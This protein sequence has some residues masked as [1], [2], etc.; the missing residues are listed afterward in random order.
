MVCSAKGLLPGQGGKT[1]RFSKAPYT[2][3]PD[4]LSGKPL[5]KCCGW[6]P[7]DMQPIGG[8]FGYATDDIY[9]LEACIFSQI[10]RNSDE[11][12]TLGVGDPFICDFS[13]DKFASL[14]QTLLSPWD[15]PSTATKCSKSRTCIE[16]EPGEKPTCPMCWRIN[17]GNGD[18]SSLQG[19]NNKLCGFCTNE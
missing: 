16:V 10:C 13:E 19:C 14:Q 3:Q 4:G 1:I 5:G 17:G 8:S 6:V 15:E 12:F 11:L 2:L 9:Y 18:C 7:E